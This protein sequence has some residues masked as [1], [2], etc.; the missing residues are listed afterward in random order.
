MKKI[1]LFAFVVLVLVSVCGIVV[2]EENKPVKPGGADASV[3]PRPP[4]SKVRDR[5][6]RESY[7]PGRSREMMAARQ[8]ERM[9]ADIERATKDH[10]EFAAE[11]KAIQKLAEEEGAKK[12]SAKIQELIDKDKKK[13]EMKTADMKKRMEDFMKRMQGGPGGGGGAKGFIKGQ[14][15]GGSRGRQGKGSGYGGGGKGPGFGG[16]K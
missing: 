7:M 8:T 9:K 10:K 6:A 4:R 3:K 1:V 11:L 12:T 13:L 16:S 2:G 5:G 14:R 15:L